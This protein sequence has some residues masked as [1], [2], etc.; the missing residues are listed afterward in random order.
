VSY[1]KL[2]LRD[3]AEIVWPLDD[4]DDTSTQSA[5]INFFTDNVNSYSASINTSNTDV[6]SNPIVFGGGLALSLSSS[7]VGLSI[8]ALGKF[9]ELYSSKDSSISLW[10]QSNNLFSTEY[11]IFKKRNYKN[12]GLFIK[13]N[14]LIFRYGTTASYAE[15]SADVVDLSEPT[16]IVVS[17]TFSGLSL[18]INGAQFNTFD[19][20]PALDIDLQH[21][22]N[23]FIDFY[24]PPQKSWVVDSIAFYPNAINTSVAKRHY[25]Y[26]L[27]KTVTDDVFYTRGGNLYNLSTLPTEK[28]IDINWDYKD[29]W[30][31]TELVDLSLENDG[32]K[33]AQYS[34]PKLYSF[35]N[36]IDTASGRISFYR[37]SSATQAS[38]IEIDKLYNKIGGGEYPFFIKFKLNGQLPFPYLSQRLVSYGKFPENEIINFDLY[39]D[40][41]N[42]RVVANIPGSSSISFPVSN[43]SS[44]PSFYVGM[45]FSGNTTVFFAEENQSIQSASFNY[46]SS[47][48]Y[49]I[50]PLTPYFPPSADISLRIGS[51][52][53]YNEFSF[54]DNV[55]DVSQFNGSFEEF[56]VVQKDFS[57]SSTF[58]HLNSYRKDKY[59]FVYDSEKNRFKVSSY[60]YGSFNIHSINFSE[61]V[62]DSEQKLFANVIK[63]GYPDINSASQVYFYVTHLSYS[64]SVIYPKT[65]L[66]YENYLSFINNINLSDSYLKFDFEVYSEDSIN[67]PPKIKY[68]QMQTF[69]STEQYLSM[70]DDAGPDYK[71]YPTSSTVFLPE[72]RYTPT[73]FMTDNSGISMNRT[74]SDFSENIMSKPLDPRVI[75]GLKLWLDARFVNGLN[76]APPEDDSRLTFWQDLSNNNND[77]IQT[78][79]AVAPVYRSQALNILRSNQLNGSDTDNISFITPVNATIESSPAAAINGNKGIKVI[80]STI[81]NDSYIDLTFNTASIGTFSD[82][83]Y[84]IVGSI[85]LD[86]PQTASS[87]SVNARKIVILSS[88]GVSE[89]FTAS[90]NASNN[91]KGIYSLSAVFTTPSSSIRSVLRFYNGSN[92]HRDY[93]SWDNLGVYPATSSSYISQWRIPLTLNDFPTIKFDGYTTFMESSASSTAPNSLY[94]VAR[95][96]GDSIILQS[97]TASILYSNSASYFASY[98]SAQNYSLSDNKFKLFSILNNGTSA[99]L[100]INGDFVGTKNTGSLSIDKLFIGKDLRGDISAVV[101][102]EG[103]NSIKD[104][105]RIQRWLN[106]SFPMY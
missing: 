70:R 73:I 29:E 1:S 67:Y 87:L 77:S 59:R 51:S 65:L 93:V 97:T 69:K 85:K 68:F 9:S 104:R 56:L 60:G 86:K 17:K 32:I 21:N 25:V 90:S 44:S 23:D 27:G 57:A 106:E 15:V 8:P 103:I 74:I 72:I 95:N 88:D 66:S 94:V 54:T 92:D 37:S 84:T 6:V 10:F 3:S 71:L 47:D 75:D 31:L 26:G 61:Y 14:Y 18:T 76:A 45:K 79:S 62:S 40:Q 28:I 22:D 53:N 78:N 39:N 42:Y 20:I 30:K 46:V 99:S 24:G 89:T 58:Q 82:Q 98:G 101:L 83:T 4:I 63:I 16:H 34:S 38:Y 33:S 35:D 43:I 49:G 5:A 91:S 48:G 7:A 2:I 36:N 52:L 41:N 102:Y 80:P 50:D 96:F 11:P 81:S 19:N 12:I 105:E 13:D 55:Y 64:G 100:F